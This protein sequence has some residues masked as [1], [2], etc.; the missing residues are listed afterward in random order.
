MS[1]QNDPRSQSEQKSIAR[2][3]ETQRRESSLGS[4]PR[5]GYLQRRGE[6]PLGFGGGFDSS[7]RSSPF[8]LM[9]RMSEE[10]D[11]LFQSFGMESGGYEGGGLGGREAYGWSPAIEVT[12]REG[13]LIVQCELPGVSASDVKVEITNDA[14]ILEGER[15]SEREQ[16]DRGVQRSERQYGAFYRTIPLPEGVNAEQATARYENGVLEITIPTP[17]QREERRSIPVQTTGTQAGQTTE[18]RRQAA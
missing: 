1:L 4:S 17:Q 10:M 7:F 15:R 2:T 5:S 16:N 6:Y 11:R 13:K 14:L 8:S 12:Q 18:A 3:G 9:R